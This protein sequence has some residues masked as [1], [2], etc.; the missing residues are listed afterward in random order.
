MLAEVLAGHVGGTGAFCREGDIAVSQH[1]AQ[2]LAVRPTTEALTK[3]GDFV[4]MVMSFSLCP[5]VLCVLFHAFKNLRRSHKPPASHR[6]RWR[7]SALRGGASRPDSCSALD[8]A[9]ALP[10]LQELTYI[11]L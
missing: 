4:F 11:R 6:S 8:A 3:H 1:S 2:S 7:S 9:A 5:Y 10:V